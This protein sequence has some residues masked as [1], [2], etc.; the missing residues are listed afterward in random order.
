MKTRVIKI[1]SRYYIQTAKVNPTSWLPEP[2]KW[3]YLTYTDDE[4]WK[5]TWWS[6]SLTEAIDKAKEVAKAKEGFEVV[7]Q[8]E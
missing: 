7:W 2:E 8:S 6:V 5:S 1:D 3:E 4:I